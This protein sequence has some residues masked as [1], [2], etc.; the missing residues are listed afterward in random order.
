MKKDDTLSRRAFL[1][2]SAQLASVAALG[3]GAATRAGA[4][5]NNAAKPLPSRI[6]IG[7]IGVGIRGTIL[8]DSTKPIYGAERV[9]VS[10]LYD[11]HLTR[12][13]EKIGPNV[14]TT[15]DYQQLLARPDIDAVVIAAPDHWHLPMLREALQA[16]K[17]VYI[18]K[19][20][21]HKVEDG[22]EMIRLVEKSGKVVQVGSQYMSMGC[23][24]QAMD[25]IRSGRLGQI[26]LVEGRTYRNSS[27]G[28]WYYPIPPDAGPQTID[29]QKFLGSAPRQEF[30]LKRFFQWRLFWD[31]SG[32]LATDLFVHL[33]TAT[34]Q[35]MEVS[36]PKTVV[37][38]GDTYR[39]KNYREVPD[40][41]A[42][43]AMYDQN[44]KAFTFKLTSTANNGHNEPP[45]VFYGTEG[46]LEYSGSSMKFYYEPRRE[47]YTYPTDSWAQATTE[48]FK[49]IMQLNDNLSP[50]IDPAPSTGQDFEFSSPDAEESTTAHLRNFIEAIR[51]GSKPIEDI[52][53]GVS[54]VNV[55]HMV[56]LSF[57]NGKIVRW[58]DQARKVEM[59]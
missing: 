32:G 45:L 2:R 52:R 47:N 51:G 25:L 57:R 7:Y 33:I 37:G 40:Q 55:A 22:E 23:A 50:L 41:L 20:L 11:G 53:T 58:N 39:W 5:L 13:K 3:A 48:Q 54:A 42:A 59:V 31:Y 12:A 21:S 26:T 1:G 19:P 46:T 44:G 18:E 34:H 6:G 10:D 8:Y 38:F 17:H 14:V 27:T 49:H 56:N 4:Q 9:A 36:A 16:G 28:A 35:L 29:W 30:D 24:K 15:K 43:M